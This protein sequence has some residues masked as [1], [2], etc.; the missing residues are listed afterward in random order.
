[1]S[2][3]ILGGGAP[4]P[5]THKPVDFAKLANLGMEIEDLADGGPLA[6]ETLI[7][8]ASEQG[9]APSHL[10][11]ATALSTEVAMAPAAATFTVCAGTCQQYGALPLMDALCA[12]WEQRRDDGKS[13]FTI[14]PR[15]C[16]DRCA[17][18][19]VVTLTTA[20][21]TAVIPRATVQAMTEAVA[22]LD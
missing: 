18:G 6:L 4:R 20:D 13:L 7:D 10:L 1:M 21:G 19:P 9:K 2:L 14:A 16:L 11:A 8:Y 12:Q 3:T 5:P 17:D 22:A 15:R